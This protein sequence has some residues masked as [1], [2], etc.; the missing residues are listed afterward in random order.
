[1]YTY[2]IE[3]VS[4]GFLTAVL[5]VMR[6]AV[7]PHFIPIKVKIKHSVLLLCLMENTF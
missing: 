5:Y 3:V 7:S 6:A 2:V 1:M 4:S